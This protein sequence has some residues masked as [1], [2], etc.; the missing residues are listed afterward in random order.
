MIVWLRKTTGSAKA[1]GMVEFALIIPLLLLLIFGVIELGRLLFIYSSTLTA[2]REAAR[3][4]SAAGQAKDNQP[5]YQDCDGIRDAAKRLGGLAGIR[6]EDILISYDHGPNTV[7]FAKSCPA[8]QP[9]NLGDRLVVQ[10]VASYQPIL[11]LVKV[12]AFPINST[13]ARTILKDVT[14]DGTPPSPYPTNT[15]T[16]IPPTDTPIPPTQPIHQFRRHRPI[17]QFRRS[18]PAC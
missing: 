5:H 16:A 14:I 2:S 3:Y 8:D 13:T 4:G 9:V 10:I 7:V 6:D 15:S 17:H 11:P 12:A 18:L 1:Q